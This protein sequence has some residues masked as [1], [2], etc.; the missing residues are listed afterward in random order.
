MTSWG[1]SSK[2][3]FVSHFLEKTSKDPKKKK[4]PL[5]KIRNDKNEAFLIEKNAEPDFSLEEN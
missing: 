3:W 5:I 4:T 2:K 1:E